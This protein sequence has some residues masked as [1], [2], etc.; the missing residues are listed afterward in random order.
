[1]RY[2][3]LEITTIIILIILKHVWAI[4]GFRTTKTL[5]QSNLSKQQYEVKQIAL[6]TIVQ[7]PYKCCLHVFT[8]L[9]LSKNKKICVKCKP[10]EDSSLSILSFSFPLWSAMQLG[11]SWWWQWLW[12]WWSQ[13]HDLMA[14]LTLLVLCG[15]KG[16]LLASNSASKQTP[17]HMKLM[18]VALN[19]MVTMQI[20]VRAEMQCQWSLH[21]WTAQISTISVTLPGCFAG[22]S[23]SWHFLFPA[24]GCS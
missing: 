11:Q 22:K 4:S 3:A 9:H 6:W 19:K 15:Q 16:P 24:N 5:R 10:S 13:F 1:M 23:A 2:C 14:V 8:W 12:W 7:C 18:E 17:P 21:A 20:N